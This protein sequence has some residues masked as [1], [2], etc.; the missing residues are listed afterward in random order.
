[1]P[2]AP[3]TC[4][5]PVEMLEE[6]VDTVPLRELGPTGTVSRGARSMGGRRCGDFLTL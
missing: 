2:R 6:P 1:M 5:S 3:L 4:P